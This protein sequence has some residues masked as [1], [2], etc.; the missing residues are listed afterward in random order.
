MARTTAAVGTVFTCVPV[1]SGKRY[2]GS[3]TF[4]DEKKSGTKT[5]KKGAKAVQKE[6]QYL[7]SWLITDS[8]V[9]VDQNTV[10]LPKEVYA[11][12]S[13]NSEKNAAM[14][15]KDGSFTTI[16]LSEKLSFDS[17]SIRSSSEIS[18][19][20]FTKLCY[21]K[22]LSGHCIAIGDLNGNLFIS[23]LDDAK[24]EKVFSLSKPDVKIVALCF[25][26]ESRKVVAL[27]IFL[28]FIHICW[29]KMNN[30]SFV[31]I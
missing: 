9:H 18:S 16:P 31:T 17:S 10:F 29:I 6:E 20:I 14:I 28:F 24:A 3:I 4:K 27:C 12:H 8:T 1:S 25:E 23:S 2:F 13:Y 19:P 11:M 22:E 21:L 15:F 30:H 26:P 7:T 5:P